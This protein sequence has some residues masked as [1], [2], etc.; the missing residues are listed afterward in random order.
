[1]KMNIH[2]YKTT[3]S[4]RVCDGIGI[5]VCLR[6]ICRKACRFKSDQTHQLVSWNGRHD[7]LG[8]LVSV[9]LA[10]VIKLVNTGGK[11]ARE[12]VQQCM[13]YVC[14]GANTKTK[15]LIAMRSILTTGSL[16]KKLQ[17]IHW[18]IFNYNCCYSSLT[19][20]N[21]NPIHLWLVL[22]TTANIQRIVCAILCTGVAKCS[23]FVSR[24]F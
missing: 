6:N 16:R 7:S 9:V 21:I 22:H 15:K 17:S 5:R 8:N 2:L 18:C 20:S 14:S 3:N 1:M 11:L 24:S 10:F 12:C 13:Q 19:I 23:H 4:L